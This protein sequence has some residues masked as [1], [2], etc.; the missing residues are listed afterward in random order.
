MAKK[1]EQQVPVKPTY[2]VGQV[3]FVVMSEQNK[4][5]PC[6]V[7]E[8]N[9]KKTLEGDEITYRVVFGKDSDKVYELANINGEVFT[10]PQALQRS[11]LDNVTRFVNQHIER[12]TKSAEEWY[13]WKPG[14]L[15]GQPNVSAADVPDVRTFENSNDEGVLIDLPDGRQARAKIKGL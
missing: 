14:K 1:S 8:E 10:T 12:A 9:T 5:I 7:I 4:V 13:G 3:L 2:F 11:M 6:R 15:K